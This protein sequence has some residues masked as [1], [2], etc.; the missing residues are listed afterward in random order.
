LDS[1][2]ELRDAAQQQ[3]DIVKVVI[4][5]HPTLMLLLSSS[6]KDTMISST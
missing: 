6:Q 1:D 2:V 5:V 4:N 3:S